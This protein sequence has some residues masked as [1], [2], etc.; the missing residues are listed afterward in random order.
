MD[1]LFAFSMAA[2]HRG[3]GGWHTSK[4]KPFETLPPVPCPP[5]SGSLHNGNAQLLHRGN[6]NRGYRESWLFSQ[7][8][9]DAQASEKRDLQVLTAVEVRKLKIH[10][11]DSTPPERSSTT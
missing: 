11:A 7:S 1:S 8:E 9:L 5:T 10:F 3:Q 2:P 4:A 6:S